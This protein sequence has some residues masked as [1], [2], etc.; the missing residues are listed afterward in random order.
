[1]IVP[2]INLLLYAEI[3]AYPVHRSARAWWEAALNGDDLVGL[4]PVSVFGFVRISTNRRVFSEPLSVEAALA[5]VRR[6]LEQPNVT[7][8]LAGSQHLDIAFR[9][10]ARLGTACNLTTDVQIAAHAIEHQAEVHSNDGDFA[11]FEGLRWINPLA[12]GE[13]PRD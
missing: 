1:V 8:L 12:G 6:W 10:L 9:L 5:R 3:D 4:A 11:R 2:D 13:H 7:Y